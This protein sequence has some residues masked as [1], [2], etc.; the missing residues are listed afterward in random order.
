MQ[1]FQNLATTSLGY[2]YATSPE[3]ASIMNAEFLPALLVWLQVFIVGVMPA[4]QNHSPH[5]R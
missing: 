1:L 3:D 5:F 4:N 2:Y